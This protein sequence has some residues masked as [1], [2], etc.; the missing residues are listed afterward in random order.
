MKLKDYIIVTCIALL[1]SISTSYLYNK[2]YVNSYIKSIPV[3]DI[4]KIVDTIGTDLM[5]D[6]NNRVISPDK[7]LEKHAQILDYIEKLVS[8]S[9]T[10]VMIKQCFINGGKDIT[11][12]V[13]N[14][15]IVKGFLKEDVLDKK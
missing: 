5:G 14:V 15:L 8:S 4:T 13:F 2:F 9:D 12:D 3:V 11:D 10:P 1:I 7:A 6:V